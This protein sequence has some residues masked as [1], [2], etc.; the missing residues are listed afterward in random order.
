MSAPL[1]IGHWAR[2]LF[3]LFRQIPAV[4]LF[5][6]DGALKHF[7]LP[8]LSDNLWFHFFFFCRRQ[9]THKHQ[10]NHVSYTLTAMSP[11]VTCLLSL[12]INE[13][14]MFGNASRR[15]VQK[16]KTLL[17]NSRYDQSAPCAPRRGK[18]DG[19]GDQSEL[20]LWFMKAELLMLTGFFFFWRL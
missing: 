18:Q 19:A 17:A 9:N 3:L 10:C 2:R 1:Y 6:V 20:T 11:L 16:E 14:D 8:A 15:R 5:M 13:H 4:L 12:N 7:V